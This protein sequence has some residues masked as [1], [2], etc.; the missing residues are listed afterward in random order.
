MLRSI[1]LPTFISA[2][3]TFQ[4]AW[5]AAGFL[6]D[7]DTE[8]N[9]GEFVVTQ[10]DFDNARRKMGLDNAYGEEAEENRLMLQ[11]LEMNN[12]PFSPIPFA[13]ENLNWTNVV[14]V[15][16]NRR[17]ITVTG[18]TTYILNPITKYVFSDGEPTSSATLTEN[19]SV[20]VQSITGP[21]GRR[22]ATKVVFRAE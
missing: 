3:L 22:V 20:G 14:S 6:S 16:T 7:F 1:L 19:R 18:G 5:S 11:A 12:A 17:S 13:R 15:A 21:G 4:P 2:I 9:A 10:S 8:T